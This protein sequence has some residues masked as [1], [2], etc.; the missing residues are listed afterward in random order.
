MFSGSH[1]HVLDG[2][3]RTSLPKEFRLLLAE[4]DGTPWITALRDCLVIFPSEIWAEFQRR[5]SAASIASEPVQQTRRLFTGMAT[6]CP[7]DRQG[8]ILIPPK[9]RSWAHLE[10]DVV[11][12]G[13]GD[14]IEV[15]DRMRHD[16]E[17]EGIRSRYAEITQPLRE[18]GL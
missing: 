6:R 13:V 18:Y 7:S 4:S 16:Q 8:R 15:W 2:K 17:M 3:G 1:D 5:L 12:M 9:L 10:R 14:W 11:L